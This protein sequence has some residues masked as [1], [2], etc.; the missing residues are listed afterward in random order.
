MNTPI[1]PAFFVIQLLVTNKCA[2]V[3]GR[4]CFILS[5][6]L[7]LTPQH[8]LQARS[9]DMPC[10]TR[11]RRCWEML[12]CEC[13]FFR[14]SEIKKIMS[15]LIQNTRQEFQNMSDIFSTASKPAPAKAF[16]RLLNADKNSR[17]QKTLPAI[18][19]AMAHA[20]LPG[21]AKQHY[22]MGSCVPFILRYMSSENTSVI[23]DTKSIT[24]IIRPYSVGA[25]I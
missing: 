15:D 16:A 6:S 23:P 17:P 14:L 1:K 22:T 5:E 10:A 11:V 20:V 13:L 4:I 8:V 3:L 19:H 24:A 9:H 12:N 7:H 18:R 2:P 21:I 25:L